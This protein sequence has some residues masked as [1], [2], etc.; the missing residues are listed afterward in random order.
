LKAG[1][2]LLC[3]YA[4]SASILPNSQMLVLLLEVTSS[5]SSSQPQIW[6]QLFSASWSEV[7]RGFHDQGSHP[8]VTAFQISGNDYFAVAY[9][10]PVPHSL[11]VSFYA[12]NSTLIYN[13]SNPVYY[14]SD[15][16][17]DVY[18][19]RIDHF[20]SG[21]FVVLFTSYDTQTPQIPNQPQGKLIRSNFTVVL[22]SSQPFSVNSTGLL[23]YFP[24][25]ALAIVSNNQFFVA[26]GQQDNQIYLQAMTGF[27][28]PS[29]SPTPPPPTPLPTPV[30]PV[31]NPVPSTPSNVPA[32]SPAQSPVMPPQQPPIFIPLARVPVTPTFI[33][34]GG[35]TRL[36]QQVI[37]YIAV[38]F[39]IT[40]LYKIWLNQ[41]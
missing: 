38:S 36:T 22:N 4:A 21:A 28:A 32:L 11:A 5:N 10:S 27:N 16:N 40:Q 19:T 7:A 2:V 34:F 39:F 18:T 35:A 23:S 9:W 33:I 6:W 31:N 12:G 17:F 37:I 24:G 14:P 8:A 41:L 15:A 1:G 25:N 29:V 30:T 3:S 26:W 13:V 20:P